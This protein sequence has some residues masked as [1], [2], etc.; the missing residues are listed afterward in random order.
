MQI[1]YK[2][3]AL[4]LFI[5]LTTPM[6]SAHSKESPAEDL[7]EKLHESSKIL[8]E[9]LYDFSAKALVEILEAATKLQR[10]IV[11]ALKF[12]EELDPSSEPNIETD[13]PINTKTPQQP[14][15]YWIQLIELKLDHELDSSEWGDAEIRL[16]LF[17]QKFSETSFMSSLFPRGISNIDLT[18]GQS[19]PFSNNPWIYI[20]QDYIHEGSITLNFIIEEE[21]DTWNPL[22]PTKVKVVDLKEKAPWEDGNIKTFY[23]YL[24]QD[25]ISYLK[26]KIHRMQKI[27]LGKSNPHQFIDIETL[28]NV[29][30]NYELLSFNQIKHYVGIDSLDVETIKPNVPD[31]KDKKSYK[32]HA[33]AVSV[34]ESNNSRFE[35]VKTNILK[36][37][38][39]RHFEALKNEFNQKVNTFSNS[40]E[41]PIWYWFTNGWDRKGPNI[42]PAINAEENYLK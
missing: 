27:D 16:F 39:S 33:F 1:R 41:Y 40:I 25:K 30:I 10:R 42:L 22:V 20:S 32:S 23:V 26:I 37:S 38:D 8:D 35:S 6:Y 31:N 2:I 34:Q 15:Y 29:T 5:T 3:T 13:E 11:N 7:K 18:Y 19:F 12:S 21:D 28:D 14:F 36:T 17:F 24:T 9:H 4:I